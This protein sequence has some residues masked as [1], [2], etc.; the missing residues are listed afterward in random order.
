MNFILRLTFREVRS[1]WRRLL[2]FFLS[3]A[4]GVGSVVA[5]RSL[6]QNIGFA[7]AFDA[8]ELLTADIEISSTNEFE[9]SEIAKI[10]DSIAKFSIV[11]GR[12]E[13]ITTASM[14][15]P[16]D[17]ENQ[18]VRLVELKGVDR[19]FPLVGNFLLDGGQKFDYRLIEGGGAV[20]SRILIEDLDLKIGDKIRLAEGEFRINATFDREPGGNSGFRLG[21]R[22][23][24]EKKAFDDAGIT[25]GSGRI[26]RRILLRTTTDPASLVNDLRESLRGTT[27]QVQSYRESQE[28]LGEQFGKTENYLA[29][30]GLLILVLGGIGVWNVSRAFVE[31]KRKTVAIL[32]CVGATGNRILSIYFLQIT[33]LGLIGSLFG[34]LLAQIGL[35]SAGAYFRESLPVN[36][37]LAVSAS[38]SGQGIFL[39]VAISLIF[40]TLP[41]L[42]IRHLKP[43]LLLNDD[44]NAHLR[45]DRTR[46]LAA[47]IAV[48]S[49]FL[50]SA[51]QAGSPAIGAAFLGGTAAV[52]T[53][54]YLAAALLIRLLKTAK[55]MGS[56]SISL[57]INSLYRPGNQTRVVLLAVGLGT[58]V[59][60][61]VQSLQQNLIREFDF[62][63]KSSLPSLFFVDIQKSQI[64]S[65]GRLIQQ[66][67]GEVP[68][69]TPT[70]RARIAFVNGIPLDF[71][72]AEMRRQQGQ[73]GREFVI[74]YRPNLDKN[75]RVTAGQWW[76]AGFSEVPEVSVEE[77]M[78]ERLAV[79]PGDSIT[80]DISG[81][82]ITA[83]IANIRRLDLRNTRT[84]FVFVFR[85]GVIESAPQTFAATVL[86]RMT[87]TER[88]RLQREIV[89]AFPN[90]QI[91]DV[92]D[93]LLAVRRLLENFVLAIS[94]VGGIVILSGILILAGSIALTKSQRVYEN[95]VLKTLGANRKSLALTLVSEYALLGF[96]AGLIGSVFAT[97]MSWV[98]CRFLLEIEWQADLATTLGGAFASGIL[99]TAVGTAANFDVLFRRPL[100]ILRTQ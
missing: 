53:T 7:V 84:A 22:V 52:A 1:S 8:R 98:V 59:V 60:L 65:V 61:A 24:I 57:A 93:I 13:A 43:S 94:F 97:A 54:L 15:R 46:W 72:K 32:K 20:A 86:S 76:P 83:R 23:F 35:L 47:A 34:V 74:T 36:M 11:D 70:V 67:T 68:E 40:S 88:Q 19:A 99:V 42:Q 63:K 38:A 73:I 41:L 69:T 85:P 64:E 45:L 14:A 90:V 48:V 66:R 37:P 80:F 75:E 87:A 21:P 95:A 28:N 5:L 55:K 79:V 2:F 89:E 58:F 96:T 92:A 31:Q 9:P 18:R 16:I 91:F 30:T 81:R 10:E 50:L 12:S 78:A 6:V 71:G 3:I 17:A 49:L 27:L 56:F 4:I 51:W 82:K 33:I 100:S 29:L 77:G 62:T 25:R 26:R 44:N 39:G